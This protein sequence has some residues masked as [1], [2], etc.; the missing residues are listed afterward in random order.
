MTTAVTL[1][2]RKAMSGCTLIVRVNP[3]SVALPEYE[4]SP[5]HG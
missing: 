1:E 5:G 4:H 3:T 2:M